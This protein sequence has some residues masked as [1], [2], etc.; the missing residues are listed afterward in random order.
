M[1]RAAPPRKEPGSRPSKPGHRCKKVNRYYRPQRF[2]ASHYIYL[3]AER[4]IRGFLMPFDFSCS[5]QQQ[6]DPIGWDCRR[7]GAL[8]VIGQSRRRCR[9]NSVS[10]LGILRGG[11][12]AS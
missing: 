11:G 12:S 5:E 4:I 2:L 9:V 1:N 3:S 6:M 10:P 7:Q 8:C